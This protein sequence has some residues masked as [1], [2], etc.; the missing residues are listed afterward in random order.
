MRSL[1]TLV[2]ILGL[3]ACTKEQP[4]SEGPPAA[5][6]PRAC[7]E[8]GCINGLRVTMDKATAWAAGGY[9]F[10][11]GVEGTKITCKGALPLKAC[12]AGPSLQCDPADRVTIGESGCA[13]PPES[14]GFSDI[15]FGGGEPP[16]EVELKIMKDGEA[17]HTARLSPTYKTVQPNG[18]GCPPVCNNASETVQIP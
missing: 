9:T 17:L 7:T 16:R 15:Q 4:G 2:M 3:G 1:V 14:H 5:G 13:L 8:I 18:A 12:D 6:G 11:I 10:E